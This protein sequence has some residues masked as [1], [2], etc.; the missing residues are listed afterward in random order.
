MLLGS[1]LTVL[2]VGAGILF[3]LRT[4]DPGSEGTVPATTDSASAGANE[5]AEVPAASSNAVAVEAVFPELGVL[6]EMVALGEGKILMFGGLVPLDQATRPFEGTWIFDATSGLWSALAPETAP[7]PRIGHAMALH[8]PTGIVVL[9]GGG[10]PEPRRCPRTRFC[11]GPEDN[12]VWHYDPGA[13]TWEDMTPPVPGEDWPAPRFGARFAYEPVTGRLLM[14]SGVGVFGD[15]FTPTFYEDTWAYDPEANRWEDLTSADPATPQ[16][17]GRTMYG[18]AWNEAAQRVMLF[19]GDSISGTD[20]DRLWAFN[21]ATAAWEDRGASDSGPY[22]RWFH[23][24][25]VDP[26]SGRLVL[27]GGTGSVLTPIT[28]GAIREVEM[29]DEVWTWSE[30]EGWIAQ[31]RMEVLLNPVAGAADAATQGII[32]YDGDE[33]VMSYDASTDRWEPLAERPE[34]PDD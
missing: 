6:H 31:N 5:A 17:I 21:P 11:A 30:A 32:V 24:A 15:Q 26:R 28:G 10:T 2:I 27:I 16:P 20:D 1:F 25:A 8:P 29:L 13:G 4:D 22:E 3:L 14:F 9:F 23:L 34:G 33:V 18:L 19:G 12:Q 7:S